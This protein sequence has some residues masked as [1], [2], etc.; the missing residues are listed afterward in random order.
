MKEQ[1]LITHFSDMV[2]ITN[3][4]LSEFEVVFGNDKIKKILVNI[5][6]VYMYIVVMH[7]SKIFN[8]SSNE[9]FS[10]NKFINLFPQTTERVNKIYNDHKDVIGKIK[11]N[12]DK[13]FAHTD[14]DFMK[15]GFSQMHIDKL[16]SRYGTSFSHLKAIEKNTERYTPVDLNSDLVEIKEMLQEVDKLC[17][18]S[19]MHID[20]ENE[21]T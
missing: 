3:L 5:E 16:S 21:K 17:W 11:N 4:F 20:L 7:L 18:D 15:L 1:E 14:K 10:L 19:I 2:S 9:P 13:L 6:G 8:R 12:R